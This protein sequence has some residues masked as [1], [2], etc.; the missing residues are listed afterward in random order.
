MVKSKQRF[1][2]S[3][4]FLAAFLLIHC[5]GFKSLH[6]A[7]TQGAGAALPEISATTAKGD[8]VVSVELDV[9]KPDTARM[10]PSEASILYLQSLDNYLSLD[11]NDEK[12][13][14]I[15]LWKGN[16]LYNQGDFSKALVIYEAIRKKFPQNTFY[17]EASQ[18]AAQSYGQ[19]GRLKDAE[20]IYRTMLKE[21]D[22]AAKAEATERLAQSIYLQAEKKEKH[23]ELQSASDAY[24]RVAKEF[25]TSEF[26]PVALFNSGVMQ[27]KQKKWKEAIHIYEIFFDA[28]FESKLLAKVLFREAK[29]RELDGQWESAGL[30]YLNLVR[31]YPESPDA[32]PSLYNAGFAFF[33]GK[34]SD[35]AA[36]AFELYAKK[37]PQNVEAPNLLFRAVELYGEQQNWEKVGELQ[38]LFTR[39][40]A[41]DKNRLIQALCM[42]GTAAFQRGQQEEAVQL[43]KQA[44]SEFAGLKNADASA[45]FYAAQ[46]QHTL[47]EIASKRM[48]ALVI[49]ASAYESDLKS[50]TALLKSAVDEFIKV[51]DYRIVDWS[52]R[53]A[54]SLGQGFED[55]GTEVYLGARKPTK[56]V[57]DQ[58]D[59][60][61]DAMA[62]LSAAYAKAQK[63]YMQVLA[64][65]R[66]QEVNNK[67]VGDA[68]L[69]MLG[70][71]NAYAGFQIKAMAMVAQVIRVDATTP[72]KAIAGKLQQISRM[73]PYQEQ[74]MKYF[75]SFFDIAQEYELDPKTIDT[76]GG[77]ILQGTRE[78]GRHY[79]AAADMARSAPFPAGFQAMERFYYQVK[80]LQEG[81]PKLEEKAMDN[82]QAGLDFAFKYNLNKNTMVDSLKLDLGRALF[83]QAKC[84][85]LLSQEA[86]TN[87][88]IPT[89]A[90]PEQRK[91]YSE[92]LETAGYQLQDQSLDR[93]RKLIEKVISGSIAT[94]WGELAFARLFQI[95]PDKWTHSSE[96]DTTL[97]IFTSKDW[98]V[99]PEFPKSGWPPAD[100]SVWQRSR[101]GV[102]PKKNYSDDVA[103]EMRFLWAGDKGQG[104]KVDSTLSP[105]IP[106]KQIW[107]QVAFKLPDSVKGMELK[108]VAPQEWSAQIDQTVVLSHKNLTGSW[109]KGISM[110]IWP[111]VSRKM[112]AGTH[113]F[114][115]SAQ[116]L[117]ATEGF[118]IWAR[119][120]IRFKFDGAGAVFPWNQGKATPEYLK[121]LREQ[122]IPIP[123]FTTHGAKG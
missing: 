93:Y 36:K 59:Q 10:P 63:Q 113:Y 57:A 97:D 84:L 43:M 34:R 1:L 104:P 72:E 6:K 79:L 28:Y 100:S 92:K 114:R 102:M 70:M 116:N 55:F 21:S 118:G 19:L 108:I 112:S 67:W 99:I 123:N 42:G 105:Y 7:P 78:L 110:D 25:P 91:V 85:D 18:M 58:L 77:R 98:M 81:I 69:H 56:I 48:R 87:P 75:N 29:C 103:A 39:R 120:R 46:A 31:A 107:A 27:E 68:S 16:H 121:S 111:L 88:P 49:R 96:A 89:E 61:E 20:T 66:K 54:F 8:S 80:L 22:G 38:S 41:S 9:P 94:E 17:G 64:I 2:R 14:E 35:S 33:N 40:Y 15:M 23:G 37:Y 119:L 117:K 115:I 83:I 62:S 11:S 74:G 44:V 47:G 106:W 60:E 32:E 73:T 13:P 76:L 30:K 50:K 45:R 71:A 51:L 5:A 86:L 95:E 82:F 52:L 3:G 4:P 12:I 90:G 109:D 53:A 101:I 24:A 26:A 122:E 65:G